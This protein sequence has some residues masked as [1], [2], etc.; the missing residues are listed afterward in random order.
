MDI[1]LFFPLMNSSSVLSHNTFCINHSYLTVCILHFISIDYV[2]KGN[3][4]FNFAMMHMISIHCRNILYCMF[5]I[6]RL[7]LLLHPDTMTAAI[8]SNLLIT[9]C[10]TKIVSS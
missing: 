3:R 5:S 1:S 7:R 8:Q 10:F 6:G 4:R 9:V 2:Y